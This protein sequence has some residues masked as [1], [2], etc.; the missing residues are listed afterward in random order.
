MAKIK[1][2]CGWVGGWVGTWVP[3]RLRRLLG[4]KCLGQH[5]E[6]GRGVLFWGVEV[7]KRGAF[8]SGG[9]EPRHFWPN[10]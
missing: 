6:S 4:V 1:G 2:G 8:Q 9:G 10:D 7:Y 5:F 3:C